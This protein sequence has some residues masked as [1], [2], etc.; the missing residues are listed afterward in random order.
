[1]PEND[2]YENF[3]VVDD[4][5]AN[6]LLL[7]FMLQELGYQTDEAEN[8][9]KAVEMALEF[10]YSAIFMDIN[11]PI[12]DGSEATETLRSINFDKPIF[13]CSAEDN[14]NKI[15][16]LINLGFTDFI[17]KPIEPQKVKGLLEKNSITPEKTNPL[18]DENYQHKLDQ[19]SKRFVENI[20]VILTKID[21][22]VEKKSIADLK[23][24][25]H[26]L[27][28]T[29]SQFGFDRVAKI[30]RDI[31]AAINKSKIPLAIEKAIFLKAEL[32][33]IRESKQ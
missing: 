18:N 7:S 6:R 31:E 12:M 25:G 13:A 30:G 20:P 21:R 10:D 19:L 22:A 32:N 14:S 16:Q 29:A 28:G 23:R 5:E 15:K 24:I 8:G 11:M 17:C 9:E 27:K 1:M 33:K 2:D 26:K 3:L 4:S